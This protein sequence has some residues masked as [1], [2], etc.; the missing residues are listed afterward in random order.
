MQR[1]TIIGLPSGGSNGATVDTGTC[2]THGP[3]QEQLCAVWTDTGF[4]PSVASYYYARVLENPGCRWSQRVCLAN[5]VSCQ[6]GDS[7]PEELA[8][9][10]DASVPATVQERAWSSPIWYEPLAAGE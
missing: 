1:L 2:E 3:G 5:R 10:C 4:D 7:I 6:Q 9:C 8:F